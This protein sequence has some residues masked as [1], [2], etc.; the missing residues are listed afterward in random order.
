MTPIRPYRLPLLLVL[1]VA[2]PLVA[3]AQNAPDPEVRILVKRGPE[4]SLQVVPNEVAICKRAGADCGGAVTWQAQPGA[5][6]PQEGERLVIRH[7]P[8]D[9]A[10]RGC[11]AS[12]TFEIDTAGGSVSSGAVT[13]ACAA[14]ITWDYSVELWLGDAMIAELDPRVVIGAR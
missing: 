7:K 1:V 5:A 6:G 11:F 10:S 9:E 3:G 2:V 12:E 14:P 4:T 13:E 8:S